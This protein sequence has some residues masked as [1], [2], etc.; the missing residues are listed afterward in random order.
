MTDEDQQELKVSVRN[1]WKIFG[2]KDKELLEED[3]VYSATRD[4]VQERTEHVIAIRDVSFDVSTG[5]VF[6]VMGLSGSGKSTLIRCLLRLIEPTQGTVEV[7]GENILE[8]DKD[9]LIEFRRKKASMVFQHYGLLPHRNIIDNVAFGLETQGLDQKNRRNQAREALERVGLSGWEDSYPDELS[10]GMQQRVGIA[11]ALALDPEILLMDE[12]F[13]GLDPLIRRQMQIELVAL[14]EQLGKTIIFIT[15]DLLE[16][17]KLG[18]RIAI[19]KDGEIVQL[20]TPEQIVMNPIGDYVKE[21]VKDVSKARVMGVKSIMHEPVMLDVSQ[22]PQ[23]AQ[24]VMQANQ[25]T[26]AY[27]V[28]SNKLLEGLVTVKKAKKA[29]KNGQQNLQEILIDSY[30]KV[31]P[32]TSVQDLIPIVTRSEYPIAVVNNEDRLLGTVD[33]RAVLNSLAESHVE[34][35]G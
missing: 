17:L 19:L 27:V 6:V 35:Y 30:V 34:Q 24:E 21:F 1:L 3:W 26:S 23:T 13:S 32:N 14:Q 7:D 20:G 4:E 10:G 29:A 11:R 12:P 33:R 2:S 5:E 28:D 15:H 22:S 9:Q 31:E 8:Y 18:D 25:L 16:A